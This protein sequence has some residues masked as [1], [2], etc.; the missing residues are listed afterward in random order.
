MRNKNLLRIAFGKSL[1]NIRESLTDGSDIAS[2][3]RSLQVGDTY[4][5]HIEGGYAPINS[6]KAIQ[7]LRTFE[8]QLQFEPVVFLMSIM[9]YI[10]DLIKDMDEPQQMGAYKELEEIVKN[11]TGHSSSHAIFVDQ[12]FGTFKEIEITSGITEIR[13]KLQQSGAVNVMT[14]FI[15]GKWENREEQAEQSFSSLHYLTNELKELPGAYVHHLMGI[16][17]GLKKLPISFGGNDTWKWEN[18]YA[19]QLKQLVVLVRHPSLVINSVSRTK[20]TYDFLFLDKF[21]SMII[22]YDGEEDDQSYHLQFLEELFT[23]ERKKNKEQIKAKI[24][25]KHIPHHQAAKLF[26]VYGQ[27]NPTII[28]EGKINDLYVFKLEDAITCGFAV[29][30]GDHSPEDKVD[31]FMLSLRDSDALFSKLLKAS[32]L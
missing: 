30:V 25:F 21:D 17:K 3:A 19:Q 18:E 15:T 8:G 4:Y 7:L 27:K 10:D 31:G 23:I 16:G 26:T 5:R 9:P 20:F 2:M 32:H 12:L 29:H 22:L 13:K 11:E 14:Q 24:K 6:S 1:S 28:E